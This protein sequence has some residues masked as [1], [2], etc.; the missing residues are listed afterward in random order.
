MRLPEPHHA[1]TANIGIC[2]LY[3]KEILSILFDGTLLGRTFHEKINLDCSK[4]DHNQFCTWYPRSPLTTSHVTSLFSLSVVQI[5][6]FPGE[7]TDNSSQLSYVVQAISQQMYPHPLPAIRPS[8]QLHD[9]IICHPVWKT[10]CELCLIKP[11]PTER[12]VPEFRP[13][14]EKDEMVQW[15]KGVIFMFKNTSRCMLKYIQLRYKC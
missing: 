9:S 2:C 12:V 13:H 8:I 3:F 4:V 14:K 1:S 11:I 6:C 10:V 15:Y 7:S 5:S